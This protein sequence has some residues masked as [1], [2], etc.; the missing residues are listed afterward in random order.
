MTEFFVFNQGK[1]LLFILMFYF[2]L[3]RFQFSASVNER[4]QTN[5]DVNNK[6]FAMICVARYPVFGVSDR[7]LYTFPNLFIFLVYK[8]NKM[9]LNNALASIRSSP[10]SS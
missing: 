7:V 5:A 3:M 6:Q 10:A 4:Q 9:R 2:I 1:R 8:V